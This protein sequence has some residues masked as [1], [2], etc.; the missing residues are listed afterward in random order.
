MQMDLTI[1]SLP[2]WEWLLCGAGS[3]FFAKIIGQFADDRGSTP[4]EIGRLIVGFAGVMCIV[5]AVLVFLY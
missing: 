3:L 1:P 2:W 4:A 5:I